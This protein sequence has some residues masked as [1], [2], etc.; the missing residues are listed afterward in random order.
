MPPKKPSSAYGASGLP[1]R[2]EQ[3]ERLNWI[4]RRNEA[5]GDPKKLKAMSPKDQKRVQDYLKMLFPS[6]AK[7]RNV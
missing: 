6:K 1:P 2:Q 7:G 5:V 4:K 3:S